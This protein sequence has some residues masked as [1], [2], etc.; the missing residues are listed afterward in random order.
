[1]MP[2]K[3]ILAGIMFSIIF[4]ILGFPILYIVLMIATSILI[5]IDHVFYYV[6]KFKRINPIEMNRYFKKDAHLE[7]S[8]NLLPLL[9][10]HNMETLILL[11]IL[12]IYFPI[13]SYILIGVL[14]HM[15]LDW[16]A[17]PIL[18]YPLIIKLSL[19]LV[20]IENKKRCNKW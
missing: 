12:S 11:V 1:M 6:A 9:I 7:N 14:I 16:K 5:D 18:G 10:F 2:S 13:F 20:I 15:I 17:M 4:F 8:N 3:H 19:I